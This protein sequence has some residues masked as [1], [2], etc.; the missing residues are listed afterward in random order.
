[1]INITTIKVN[2]INTENDKSPK[3]RYGHGVLNTIETHCL[4]KEVCSLRAFV[5]VDHVEIMVMLKL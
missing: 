2:K 1:M 5:L 4:I 3:L